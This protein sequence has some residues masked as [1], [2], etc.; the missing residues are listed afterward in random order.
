[1]KYKYRNHTAG[2]QEAKAHQ[3]LAALLTHT[4]KEN[5][6]KTQHMSQGACI[7]N[8]CQIHKYYNKNNVT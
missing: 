5:Y 1:V 7:T 8:S 2:Y 3:M 6:E 4:H